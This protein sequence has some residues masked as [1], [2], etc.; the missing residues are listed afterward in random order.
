[1]TGIR[2]IYDGEFGVSGGNNKPSVDPKV[3]QLLH[4][5]AAASGIVPTLESATALH[6]EIAETVKANEAE[7]AKHVVKGGKATEHEGKVEPER[8]INVGREWR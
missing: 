1:M 2:K 8:D 6:N 5:R 7:N 3:L 4:D